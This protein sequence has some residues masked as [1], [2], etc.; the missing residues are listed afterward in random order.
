MTPPSWD[1]TQ[2]DRFADERG[3]PFVDLIARIRVAQPANVVD[4]GCG[5]GNLTATLADKWP[6]A[7]V[8]GVDNDP[9]MLSAAAKHATSQVR[10]ESGDVGTWTA[11]KPVD[12]IVS[13]AALQWIPQHLALLPQLVDSITSGGAVALQVPG[14]LEDPQHLA[15]RQVMARPRWKAALGGLPERALSSYPA[16]VYQS[17]LSHLGCDVETWE[18][19]YVHVLQGNSPV[20]E[21]VKGTALRPVLSALPAEEAEAFCSELDELLRVSYGSFTWGTPFPF[22]RIFAVAHKPR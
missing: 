19:T 20:L 1:P 3:R 5:P 18:T 10:F 9:N 16:M 14:N 21:W 17:A 8:L 7:S 15:I 11:E 13:N 22:K 2:Y 12:V 6:S 4:L